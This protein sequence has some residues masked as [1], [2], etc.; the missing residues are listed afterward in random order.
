[1]EGNRAQ[2]SNIQI[3]SARSSP[4]V[5]RAPPPPGRPAPYS[6]AVQAATPVQSV[7]PLEDLLPAD[8]EPVHLRGRWGY[9]IPAES[10]H[11]FVNQFAS[12]A[13]TSV[14]RTRPAMAMGVPAEKRPRLE[15]PATRSIPP[16]PY[17]AAAVPRGSHQ[18]EAEN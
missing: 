3:V 8:S 2:A 12:Q 5:T 4:A 13:V 16:P 1:M 11:A 18:A 6:P 7:T 15:T 10:V 9:F 14:K 17:Q